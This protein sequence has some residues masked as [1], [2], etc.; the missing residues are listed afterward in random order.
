MCFW[1]VFSLGCNE[2]SCQY[3]CSRLP[4]KVRLQSDLLCVEWDVK[5]CL[6]VSQ[7][8]WL[9]SPGRQPADDFV[10][11][12]LVGCYYSLPGKWSITAVWPLP[13]ITAWWRGMCMNNLPIVVTG[14]CED[15]QSNL[16][17]LSLDCSAV[18]ITPSCNTWCCRA[19]VFSWT[20]AA[21][22]NQQ[23]DTAT[24]TVGTRVLQWRETTSRG[25]FTADVHWFLFTPVATEFS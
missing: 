6:T 21:R 8:N 9:W 19:A 20:A 12:W 25:M 1:C 16:W 24:V 5:M 15:W 4:G 22:Q 10:I 23:L 3:Q 2:S 14:K 18:N 17:P 11:K 13:T 7:Q